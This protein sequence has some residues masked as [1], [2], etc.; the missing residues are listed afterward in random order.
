MSVRFR[1]LS[2]SNLIRFNQSPDFPIGGGDTVLI[3]T[4]RH[5]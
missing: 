1:A 4:R 2:H 3:Q 5:P